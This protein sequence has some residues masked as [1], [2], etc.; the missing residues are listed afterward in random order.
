[1]GGGDDPGLVAGGAGP[2]VGVA[3]A[4]G[5][6]F[7]A[8]VVVGASP[9]GAVWPVAGHAR[10]FVVHRGD[11]LLCV[12][13]AWVVL[14]GPCGTSVEP[15]G[16]L[17]G[18]G[19]GDGFAAY[20][21]PFVDEV[22]EWFEDALRALCTG[23]GSLAWPVEAERRGCTHRVVGDATDSHDGGEYVGDVLESFGDLGELLG[24]VQ[25]FSPCGWW[26]GVWLVSIIPLPCTGILVYRGGASSWLGG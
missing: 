13:P 25:V 26:W 12:V 9:V 6:S 8:C 11:H 7:D 17:Y 2:E 3:V 15:G 5:P 23:E 24:G 16:G 18:H 21:G 1:M 19:P 22:D 14:L 4:G 10:D 20:P